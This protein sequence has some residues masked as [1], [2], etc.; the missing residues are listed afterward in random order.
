MN[1][2]TQWFIDNPIASKIIMLVI[3]LAGVMSYPLIAK[4][5][6]PSGETDLIRISVP[7]PGAGPEEVESQICRRIEEAVSQL[8]DIE[9]IR[10]V[11]R[12]G[13]GEVIIEVKSGG[14]TQRLLN[15][16]KANV[17]AINTFP[18]ESERPQIVELPWRFG[19]MRLQLTGD[20]D[21]R[22]LKE[23]G[24]QIRE[25]LAAL[26]SVSIVEL[27]RPRNY[28]V[29]I[30]ISEESLREFGL[31][32]QDVANAVRG[33]SVNI[34]AG[35]IRD[36][37]GDIQ[38][39]TRAQADGSID[40]GDIPVVRK[41]N[42]AVIRVRDV[43]TVIDGFEDVDYYS[44][45]N[46]R[47][48]LELE[49][50]DQT[51]PNILKT[52]EAV[53]AYVAKKSAELPDSVELSVWTDMSVG[54]RGR[55][56]TLLYNGSSGLL[57]VFVVLL[58][59][60]RPM[61]ALWVCSGI[62]VAFL[63]ALWALSLTP[64]SLNVMSMFAFI[65]ILG[66]I[67]D[68]AIIVGEAVYSQQQLLGDKR[69]GAKQGVM[70]VIGPVFFAVLSTI[71]FFIP[72][73]FLS[74]RPPT[75]HIAVPV[76]LALLFSLFESLLLLP[77]HLA[78]H[79][80][81]GL[82]LFTELLRPL[83]APLMPFFSAL[84]NKRTRIADSL[85]YFANRYY[86]KFLV[87]AVGLQYLTAM[88]FIFLFVFSFAVT[89][90][91]WLPFSFFPRVPTDYVRAVA[92][93]P[94]SSSYNQ[95][96]AT[97]Q[98]LEENG[99]KVQQAINQQYGH[100]WVKDLHATAY[101][102]TA[103]VT[104]L[105]DDDSNRPFSG[106]EVVRQW[107][108]EIGD[109]YGVTDL[110]I[111]FTIMDVSKPVS[112][113]LLSSSETQLQGFADELVMRLRDTPGVF[114]VHSTLENPANEI[115]LLLKPEAETLPVSL[116]D[117]SRQVRRAFYGE[118]VQR[119][120]RQREDVKVLVRYPRQ[121]RSYEEAL[122]TMYISSKSP[123][124]EAVQ[125]PL[126][127]VVDIEYRKTYNKIDRL[128][129]ERKATVS[130]NLQADF[131]AVEVIAEIRRQLDEQTHARYPD[132]DVLLEGEA[133][134]AAEFFHKM[135]MFF[136]LSMLVIYGLMAVMFRS[137]WQ[138]VLI[139]TAVPFGFMGAIFGHVIVG[140]ELSMM[141]M[142]GMLA[143]AGVVVNDN[144]VLIDRINQLREQGYSPRRAV[145]NAGILRFRPIVLTSVTTFL[146]LTPIL[147][148]TSFQAQFLIPMV[149]SLSFGVL[150]ATFVTLIFVPVLYLIGERI[151]TRFNRKAQQLI[152]ANS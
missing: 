32:F 92:K 93:L 96:Y 95:S 3:F 94:E 59:F 89:K 72:F 64:V 25:E 121:D 103:R 73:F 140:I 82:N 137:Y 50:I 75:A 8:A 27:Q 80:S 54:F 90:A 142:L 122:R 48:S 57:L 114:D 34:P 91:G 76:I 16:V 149:T 134:E 46:G 118:E 20:M 109:I 66:I 138:P 117:V 24:E 38:L 106:A 30:E 146:G 33:Y 84:E 105:L 71:V 98:L 124:G 147:L 150:F 23:L 83:F 129:G 44:A 52:S 145:V 41:A 60:L 115:N 69:L 39:Q 88:I 37:G 143:C 151:S 136:V 85:P 131:S 132:V 112:F 108:E 28:E 47:A 63:G 111:E 56:D 51:K 17:E 135:K 139:L 35:K 12:E 99:Y 144:V 14:D 74:D 53:K 128:D 10:S 9:E 79:G 55:L 130:A 7:Y 4:Q 65:M 68:D 42:G 126:E 62:A 13:H 152:L 36:S 119:I 29:G 43:A 31:S 97:M 86:R 100:R 148:E 113:T 120:P 67:V 78:N 58:L 15:D 61:L 133:K 2:I 81:K 102:N 110:A 104:M 18:V 45:L 70:S 141:S 5:Y 116:Q 22:A 26:P 87:R 6:F 21:E 107:R 123:S 77:S 49:I 11:A 125:L 101:G 1:A 127:S 19:M 40:F